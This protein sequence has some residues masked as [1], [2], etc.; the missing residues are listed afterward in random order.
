M[1]LQLTQVFSLPRIAT[2]VS[3]EINRS[4]GDP[5]FPVAGL[6]VLDALGDEGD[7]LFAQ[8]EWR[9]GGVLP[10]GG[11]RY[12]DCG[13]Q[14]TAAQLAPAAGTP[15]AIVQSG[16]TGLVPFM[17]ETPG[18]LFVRADEFVFRLSPGETAASTLYAVT[19][20]QRT[21]GQKISLGYDIS[22]LG[23]TSGDAV[24]P[25]ALVGSPQSA[26]TFP[27]A[28]TTGADGTATVVLTA[29]DPGNPRGYIDGQVY[30]IIY[31]PGD[32][33]PPTGAIQ[34]GNQMFSAL[35]W[36]AYPAPARPSWLHDVLP[37]FQQYANLYPVMLP[38]FN[39]A[40]YASVLSRR[41]AMQAVFSAVVTD[42][43]YMP[44]TRDLSEPK[45]AMI[46]QW[47]ADPLYLRLDSAAD[48]G[49]ALQQAV[50][51][52]HSTIPPYLCA[53]YSIKE[54]ANVA[55][56]EA[57]RSV[58]VEEMLHMALVSNLMISLGGSP[59]IGHPTF[60]PRY[61][62]ALPGGLRAGLTVRLRRC[63][64]EQIRDVFLSIEEPEKTAEPDKGGDGPGSPLDPHK[65]TIGWFYD[66]IGRAL[67]RL[68][69]EG[70]ITFGHPERQVSEWRGPGKLIVITSLADALAAL[71]EIK[72]QG[73]GASP[74]SPG[75]GD[76]E[77]AHYFRFSEIVEGRRLVT[78][79]G[80]FAYT[81]DRIPF[82]PAGVWPMID[83]P[84]QTSYPAGS[85][86]A[87]LSAQFA[88]TYQALL[89]GLH[90]T[91]NGEPAYLR[92][93]ISQMF[94]LDL[95]ARELMQTPS[96]RGDGTTAGPT[97]ELPAPL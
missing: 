83:D 12:V 62:G 19:Y 21:A 17:L 84:A 29:A 87:I 4:V 37:I 48:L 20:G 66:E 22:N 18:G 45:R 95:A 35:V 16:A 71:A 34:Q 72:D 76:H 28:V 55:A 23:P 65:F 49:L 58:A 14:L 41:R 42:A 1:Q 92:Q 73:E 91:F 50:E 46:R 81:G 97:F 64:I 3:V 79:P 15:L 78:H 69:S 60:V 53:L 77:L 68:S 13:L 80:G 26:L 47:L 31:G 54:G 10:V 38:L 32:A 5:V 59:S 9:A 24:P 40:S 43:N 90:R 74:L 11:G 27:P 56:A 39:M 94:A 88:R 96:G 86:A 52:E 89:N 75:D 6:L 63:S 25:P 44:V 36:S 57:I 30:G 93:A 51:L 61:P 70:K 2:K 8:R 67:T 85:R 33:P 82:D 7:D